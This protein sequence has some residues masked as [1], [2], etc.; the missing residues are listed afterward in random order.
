MEFLTRAANT[1]HLQTL[2]NRTRIVLDPLQSLIPSHSARLVRKEV[3]I[4][5]GRYQ[6]QQWRGETVTERWKAILD[7]VKHV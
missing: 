2:E 5:N 4:L 3:C 7:I 1:S 6:E